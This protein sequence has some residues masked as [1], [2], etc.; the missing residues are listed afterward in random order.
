[1][2]YQFNSFSRS[3]SILLPLSMLASSSMNRGEA[4]ALQILGYDFEILDT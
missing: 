4:T 1:M 2:V 3:Q